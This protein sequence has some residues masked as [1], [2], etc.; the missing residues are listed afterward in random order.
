MR[1]PIYQQ[2]TDKL[3]LT[4]SQLIPE[5]F[6]MIADGVE[7]RL[8]LAMPGTPKELSKSQGLSEEETEALCLGLY[9]KG[10][11]FKSFRGGTLAY[12][13]C[14]DMV[15][16]HDGTILWPEAPR[17]FHDLWQRFMEE[18]W[19]TF[20]RLA[21]Q[22]IPKPFT[23][24]IPVEEAVESGTQTILDVDSAQ[25]ILHG[26]DV[27]AVTPCTCRVIARKCDNPLE[28]CIQVGNAA[29]YTLDRGTG[30]ELGLEEA[31]AI[32]AECRDAGLVQVTMNKAHAG[33]FICNCCTCC[34][35]VLP[36]IRK[37]RLKLADPSRFLASIDG[38]SCV[39]CGECVD[40]CPFDAMTL[41]GEV[42][43]VVNEH[44]MGCGL[45]ASRCPEGAISLTAQ[46]PADFIPGAA[47]P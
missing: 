2:L 37:E 18:E 9:R 34:C 30:R 47:G 28:V 41:E 13:M 8:L 39:G 24:V 15:Q 33:H 19:P 11:A 29:R 12:K 35:Q 27:L 20:A 17:S 3:L 40:R 45:C 22:F 6:A 1:D 42:A 23:R 46:R 38:K 36:L 43:T 14:R 21:D 4:G 31:L 7:A 5:L 16:F 26:A 25:A 44:C 10:L 32:L